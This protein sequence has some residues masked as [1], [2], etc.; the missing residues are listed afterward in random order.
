TP[1]PAPTDTT[2]STPTDTATP[3]PAGDQIVEVGVDGFNFGPDSFTISTGDTVTWVWGNHN[4][5]PATTPDGAEW[6]GTPGAPDRTFDSGY[7]YSHTFEVAGTYEYYCAPHRSVGMT[8]S[9]T[10]E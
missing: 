1:T 9:F 5:V 4:V 7:T 2:T 10:V 8:G 6:S 3:T